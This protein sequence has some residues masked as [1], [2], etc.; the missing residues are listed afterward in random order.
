MC[1]VMGWMA[2]VPGGAG[3]VVG[4]LGITV[5][6]GVCGKYG[7]S[8]PPHPHLI[9]HKHSPQKQHV[10]SQPLLSFP[11]PLA[12]FQKPIIIIII[13]NLRT[14]PFVPKIHLYLE[15]FAEE[16][17]REMSFHSSGI[18]RSDLLHHLISSPLFH[19][20]IQIFVVKFLTNICFCL[21]VVVVFYPF[22]S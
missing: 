18:H 20:L 3:A 11:E 22:G 12:G 19:F 9:F 4:C 15:L 10:F 14:E 5:Y 1:G 7:I 17:E 21:F 13:K 8:F 6:F 16:Q 2:C